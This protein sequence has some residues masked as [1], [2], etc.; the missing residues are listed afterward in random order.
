MPVKTSAVDKGRRSVDIMRGTVDAAAARSFSW[1]EEL[2]NDTGSDILEGSVVVVLS[3]GTVALADTENDPRPTGV[4]VDQIDDGNTGQVVFGGPV[5]MVLTTGSVTAGTY[6]QTSTT[7]GEA[8]TAGSPAKAFCEFTDTGTNP[9]AFLWGGRGGGGTIGGLVIEDFDTAET[10]TTLVLH[11]DGAGG[12]EW[13]V[14]ATGGGGYRVNLVDYGAVADS[15]TDNLTAIQAAIDATTEYG[16][17]FIPDGQGETYDFAGTLTIPHS[18]RFLGEGSY[19]GFAIPASTLRQTSAND[20]AIE[21]T[22]LAAKVSFE[23]AG[24]EGPG[25]DSSGAGIYSTSD[26]EM[27]NARINGF[28]DNVC[29]DVTGGTPS[30]F[31]VKIAHSWINFATRASIYL[32][33]NVNNAEIF[34][35]HL[36]DSAYGILADGGMY[37]CWITHNAIELHSSAGIQIDGTS[38]GFTASGVSIIGN[39][40][41][42]ST[43]NGT[44]TADISLGPTTAMRGVYLAGNKFVESDV[45]GLTHIIADNVDGLTLIGNDVGADAETG[46]LLCDS[47]NTTNV[48]LVGNTFAGSVTT[49]ASTRILDETD[50]TP[51]SV[52]VANAV[53]SSKYLARADHVHAGSTGSSGATPLLADDASSPF[54][55]DDLLQN[56]DGTAWLFPDG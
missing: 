51:A 6:G 50:V 55:F 16:T 42:Q 37:G 33:G 46:S 17:V 52:G 26:V 35:N 24:L 14:D 56:D 31:Y 40:F 22:V 29:V 53:G 10:D 28:Y 44:P 32:K 12:V 7:P 5:D 27:L 15:S 8:Q 11:P 1:V 45:S 2:A 47:S 19:P 30:G 36:S 49:P 18:V 34:G 48:T 21:S 43:L 54:V 20:I 39:Y 3:D 9:P 25:G 38:G 4:V 13:G 23:N 41:E